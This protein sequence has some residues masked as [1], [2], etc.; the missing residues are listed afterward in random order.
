M[1]RRSRRLSPGD[2]L[3]RDRH[4]PLWRARTARAGDIAIEPAIRSLSFVRR[5]CMASAG[6]RGVRALVELIESCA[7]AEG[8]TRCCVGARA[9]AAIAKAAVSA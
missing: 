5:Q 1:P 2:G 8:H 6:H 7:V 3:R 9:R 4:G